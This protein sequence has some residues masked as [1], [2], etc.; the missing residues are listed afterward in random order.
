MSLEDIDAEKKIEEILNPE[1][2]SMI[3]KNSKQ[4]RML[5]KWFDF[6]G[7]EDLVK[8]CDEAAARGIQ[9]WY[10]KKPRHWPLHTT[11]D[12]EKYLPCPQHKKALKE[13]VKKTL[14]K[15]KKLLTAPNFLSNLKEYLLDDE[16]GDEM[17]AMF[18]SQNALQDDEENNENSVVPPGHAIYHLLGDP[19]GKFLIIPTTKEKIAFDYVF[20]WENISPMLK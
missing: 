19:D 12:Q 16:C 9:K 13:Q 2:M 15:K 7:R 1:Q 5:V 20:F 18:I 10:K 11:W 14:L 8:K 4:M 17:W 3:S 6:L